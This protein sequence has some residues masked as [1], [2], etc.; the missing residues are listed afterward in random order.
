MARRSYYSTVS[1]S[2]RPRSYTVAI[3]LG[4]LLALL[5]GF[6]IWAVAVFS[7]GGDGVFQSQAQDITEL[8]MA[9]NEKDEEIVR[10]TQQLEQYEGKGIAQSD[11]LV[12]PPIATPTP[13][14]APTP[15][16]VPRRTTSPNATDPPVAASTPPPAATQSPQ[17]TPVVRQPETMQPVS[18]QSPGTPGS[19]V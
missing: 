1:R 12:G 4:I 7:G 10:L 14:P 17:N 6:I 2:K 16:P 13:S 15:T 19:G 11:G 18:T 9:L 3:V 5:A 8:K